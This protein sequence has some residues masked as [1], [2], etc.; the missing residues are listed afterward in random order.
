MRPPLIVPETKP[1][2]DLLADLRRDRSSLA[3]VVDEYGRLA[4]VVSVEDI[5]EEIVGEI[6]DETDPLH[7]PIR[8]L[9]NGD[10]LVRGE[11]SLADLVDSGVKLNASDA[12][13]TSISG[14]ILDRLGR[15]PTRGETV[16]LDGYRLRVESVRGTRIETVR[17]ERK[18]ADDAAAQDG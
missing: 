3:I 16:D 1:L 11:V 4:G 2:D 6:V 8:R 5:V 14:V 7:G 9:A 18:A 10:L 12:T 17:L 13:Y 15:I